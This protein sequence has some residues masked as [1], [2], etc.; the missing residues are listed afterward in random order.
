MNVKTHQKMLFKSSNP[1][2]WSSRES[3]IRRATFW[4]Y[5]AMALESKQTC[6]DVALKNAY[7]VALKADL[8]V[9]PD[10]SAINNI[11]N[12]AIPAFNS[13]KDIENKDPAND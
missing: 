4:K 1:L 8:V 12:A 10:I 6:N 11:S 7:E 13:R 3:W 2:D 9:S 5:M